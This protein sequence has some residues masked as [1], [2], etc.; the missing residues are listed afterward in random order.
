MDLLKIKEAL[1]PE[2]LMLENWLGITALFYLSHCSNIR[3]ENLGPILIVPVI[4]KMTKLQGLEAACMSFQDK[5]PLVWAAAHFSIQ[6][7][8]LLCF[9]NF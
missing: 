5:H 2:S 3:S 4:T 1:K 7:K 6:I 9:R 8:I